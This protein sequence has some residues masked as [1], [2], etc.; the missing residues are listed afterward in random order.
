[1]SDSASAGP[2]LIIGTGLIGTSIGLA[3][4]R[5]GHDVYLSD[6][7]AQHLRTAV[8]LGA[9]TDQAPAGVRLAVAAVPPDAVATVAEGALAD[10]PDAVVTDV[11]S[12]KGAPLGQL[13]AAGA[14]VTRYVGSHPMAGS[15]HS[16]PDTATAD[17]FDGRAWAVTPHDTATPEAIAAVTRLARACGATVVE[18]SPV[19]HD[20]AVAK[21]SHLPH[22]MSVLTAAQLAGSP[23]RH[24]ALSGQG[25]RDV[26]RVAA[27][28][29][30]LWQQ[31]VTANAAE[32]AILLSAVRED[33][34]LLLQALGPAAAPPGSLDATLRRGNA[35]RR[36]IPG[37]HGAPAAH[38]ATVY[39]QVPDRPG[40][41][42]RLFADAGQAGV[43]VEDM[44]I[45]HDPARPVGLVELVVREEAAAR[46]ATEL[47][48]RGWVA[49]R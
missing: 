31:I 28:D 18:M 39:V 27:G 47:E 16:G 4:R 41:L 40:E 1:M 48:A 9:G 2:V 19:E 24:L 8:E 17:L 13:L 42:A 45:D 7:S 20:A 26:T 23:A 49:H 11:G 38:D 5:A 44:H 43:N 14:D 25:L 32:I 46:L 10:W 3:L 35:G 12:V 15:E 21:V 34:D 30:A 22:L 33:L 37:K 6:S 29:P 36:L